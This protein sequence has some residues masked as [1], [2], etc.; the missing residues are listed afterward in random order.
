MH[1]TGLESKAANGKERPEPGVQMQNVE[2]KCMRAWPETK[3]PAFHV[4]KLL[5]IMRRGSSNLFTTAADNYSSSSHALPHP[6]HLVILSP[7][8]ILGPLI[9]LSL[10]WPTEAEGIHPRSMSKKRSMI[11]STQ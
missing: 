9:D 5:F 2:G 3:S 11:N 8:R 4:G 6:P 7:C 1:Q 10:R